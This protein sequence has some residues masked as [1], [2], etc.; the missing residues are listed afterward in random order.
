MRIGSRRARPRHKLTHQYGISV[1]PK[2]SSCFV[3]IQLPSGLGTKIDAG[4]GASTLPE[5]GALSDGAFHP[6]SAR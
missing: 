5:G 3:S 6:A 1:T 2:Q 4:G